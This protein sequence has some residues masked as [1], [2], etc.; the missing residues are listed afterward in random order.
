MRRLSKGRVKAYPPIMNGHDHIPRPGDDR[1]PY[2]AFHD[3]IFKA[4]Y[5]RVVADAD[6][7]TT[8]LLRAEL[9]AHGIAKP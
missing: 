9:V 3:R 5:K 6:G 2:A 1:P 4:A 8:P 7:E